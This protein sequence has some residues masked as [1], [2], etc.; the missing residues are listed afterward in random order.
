MEKHGGMVKILS[1]GKQRG[2]DH[3]NLKQADRSHFPSIHNPWILSRK[4][5]LV[6]LSE[7]PKINPGYKENNYLLQIGLETK[8]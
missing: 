1:S 8:I 2:V 7:D 5:S 4:K 3:F 6:T